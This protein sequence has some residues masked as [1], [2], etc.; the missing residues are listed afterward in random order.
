MKYTIKCDHC[1]HIKT[2][3]VHILNTGKVDALRKL[4]DFYEEHKRSAPLKDLGITNSQYTNFCHL[5][6]FNLALRVEG[7]WVPTQRGISFIYG[8]HSVLHP[9]AVMESKVLDSN[10]EAWDSHKTERKYKSVQDFSEF[11][12]KKRGEF[13][14]EKSQA[15]QLF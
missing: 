7:G 6:Y 2:A 14:R 15:L 11:A 4:V 1:D 3:Y 5:P 10:H 8:Q 13:A 9:V 12:Y